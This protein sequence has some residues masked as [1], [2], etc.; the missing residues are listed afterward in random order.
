MPP[1][2]HDVGALA[3]ERQLVLDEHLDVT[4]PGGHQVRPQGRDAALPGP[5]LAGGGCAAGTKGHPLGEE[6][7]KV[8]LDR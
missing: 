3:R 4:E 2:E 7:G 8:G 5:V 6:V 1:D